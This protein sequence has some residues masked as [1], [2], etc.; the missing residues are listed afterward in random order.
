MFLFQSAFITAR[1]KMIPSTGIIK[2][3]PLHRKNLFSFSSLIASFCS[4]TNALKLST[5]SQSPAPHSIR[6]TLVCAAEMPKLEF[7]GTM[8]WDA[9]KT[10][11]WTFIVKAWRRFFL[12]VEG[13][14][15]CFLVNCLPIAKSYTKQYN[16]SFSNRWTLS[17]ILNSGYW[18]PLTLT[19][20][21]NWTNS[22]SRQPQLAV[23]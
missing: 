8:C 20:S 5:A 21:H 15:A 22:I 17:K 19:L 7:D 16:N 2:L 12:F 14:E 13:G 11:I 9:W 18:S 4:P 23:M 1:N 6:L 10:D 3:K